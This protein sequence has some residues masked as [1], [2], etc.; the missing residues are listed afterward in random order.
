[1]AKLDLLKLPAGSPAQL[2]ASTSEVMGSN[3][4]DRG[5][6][7]ILLEHLPHDL[8]GH[9]LPPGAVAPVHRP[10]YP[11][12]RQAGRRGPRIDRATSCCRLCV[13]STQRAKGE[14]KNQCRVTRH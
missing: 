4:N 14:I 2:G 9:T 1:M 12:C 11:T 3:T 8:L 6:F 7:G 13:N 10:E 5:R